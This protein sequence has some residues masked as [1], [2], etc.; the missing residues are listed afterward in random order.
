M[1]DFS[2]LGLLDSRKLFNYFILGETNGLA[3]RII[4]L[5]LSKKAH[6]VIL[7]DANRLLEQ[8]CTDITKDLEVI[9]VEVPAKRCCS[10][11]PSDPL[12][13][14][15]GIAMNKPFFWENEHD[16]WSIMIFTKTCKNCQI[17]TMM[18][19]KFNFPTISLHSMMKQKQ[20]F[21]NLTKLKSSVFKIQ[22]QL[23]SLDIPTVQVAINHNTPGLPKIYIQSL[24]YSSFK[25][26]G[27][28]ITLVTQYDIHLVHSIEG[29][30]SKILERKAELDKIRG[31]KKL[32]RE[33]MHETIQKTH[34]IQKKKVMK[35]KHIQKKRQISPYNATLYMNKLCIYNK[36]SC[37]LL[38]RV[39]VQHVSS[40][41]NVQINGKITF[42]LLKAFD[43]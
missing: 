23:M 43:I 38:C 25:R 18:P 10:A 6:V 33:K 4:A 22:L 19:Q 16:D 37:P 8:G 27:V 2:S 35:Q 42:S 11:P 34:G 5:E 30:I 32:F 7:N 39:Q 29:K 20:R 24:Q 9:L 1:L 17:L 40:S 36:T 28:S 13:K 21:A 12:Q 15:E 41:V 31:E 14:L 26:H 3:D